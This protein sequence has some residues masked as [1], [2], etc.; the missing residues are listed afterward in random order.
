[1]GVGEQIA[2]KL[3][4][5]YNPK[6][7]LFC[8]YKAEMWDSMCTIHE[9]IKERNI[10]TEVMAIPY[11]TLNNGKIYDLRRDEIHNGDFPMALT[12]G[13]SDKYGGSRMWDIIIFHYPYDNANN[14]TR[15]IL[16][17]HELKAFCYNLV[18]VSYSCIGDRPI[19]EQEIAYSGVRNS[20]LVIVETEEQAEACNKMLKGKPNWQGEVVGWGSAKYDMIERAY[21]PESWKEKGEGKRKI[22]LQ[23]S[24]TPYLKDKNKLGQVESII[25]TYIKDPN[26]CLIWRPHPL[27]RDTIIAHHRGELRKFEDLRELVEKSPK[28][29]LDTYD[30]PETAIKFAD[31]MISDKS[32][33]VLLWKKTGKKLTEV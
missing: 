12:R 24:I 26:V 27:L 6:S 11:Y 28:D 14:V 20:D 7:V 25:R 23:T 29:I 16:M 5:R 32:S 10:R 30:C 9:A 3:I 21:I 17:S 8:P 4:E 19:L 13:D 33:L 22:L 2:E 15:P 18:L 1:M 31:E